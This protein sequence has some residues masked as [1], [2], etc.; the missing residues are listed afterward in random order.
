MYTYPPKAEKLY[1]EAEK[2]EIVGAPILSIL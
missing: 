2:N 1:F